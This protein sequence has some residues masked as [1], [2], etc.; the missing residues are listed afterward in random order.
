MSTIF[1]DW[2]RGLLVGRP[3][4]FAVFGSVTADGIWGGAK[5]AGYGGWKEIV[6]VC[7]MDCCFTGRLIFEDGGGKLG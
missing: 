5:L 6:V 4:A 1:V 7:G 2:A 3:L